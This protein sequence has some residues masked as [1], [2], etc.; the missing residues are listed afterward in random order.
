MGSVS[1]ILIDPD[2]GKVEGLFV[3]MKSFLQSD[4]LFLSV[5]DILHVGTSITIR[6][7]DV[8]SPVDDLVRIQPLLEDNRPVIGQPMRSETGAYIGKCGDVQFDTIA[9][10]VEWLF[11]RRWFRFRRPLPLS[12]VIEVR[13]DAIIVRDPRLKKEVEDGA[14]EG[15]PMLK[16]LPDMA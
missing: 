13:R 10:Q 4:V 11:P 7:A 15:A 1:G 3:H 12:S 16:S 2:T 9:F 14:K 6:D 8:L 5:L